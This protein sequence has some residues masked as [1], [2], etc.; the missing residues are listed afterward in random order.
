MLLE[1]DEVTF[2]ELSTAIISD[3]ERGGNLIREF[4][5]GAKLTLR[6]PLRDTQKRVPTFQV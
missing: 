6:R 3:G 1:S 5:A 2:N 4:S